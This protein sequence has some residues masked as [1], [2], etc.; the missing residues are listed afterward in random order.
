MVDGRLSLKIYRNRSRVG[1]YRSDPIR[2]GHFIVHSKTA[3][4]YLS[5]NN[6]NKNEGFESFLKIL[7]SSFRFERSF[8]F[9]MR[10][11]WVV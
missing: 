5:L 1:K 9:Q 4:A 7:T 3:H 6:I 11:N 2:P 10:E 8:G